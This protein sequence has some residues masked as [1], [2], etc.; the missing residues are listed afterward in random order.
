MPKLLLEG[1]G[2]QQSWLGWKA[3]TSAWA[4]TNLPR[5]REMLLHL[6]QD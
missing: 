6:A 4:P 2:I 3:V 1:W 5:G